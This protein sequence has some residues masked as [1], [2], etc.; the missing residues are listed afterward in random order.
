MDDSIRPTAPEVSGNGLHVAAETADARSGVTL[1]PATAWPKPHLI[2]G[3]AGR[4]Y[5]PLVEG[6]R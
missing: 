5:A 2:S 3:V 1:A 6:V 4:S